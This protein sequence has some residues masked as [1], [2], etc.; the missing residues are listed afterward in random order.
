MGARLVITAPRYGNTA[1]VFAPPVARTR[2]GPDILGFL[3]GAYAMMLPYQVQ[4]TKDLN[5]ALADCCLLLILLLAPGQLKYRK[6]AWT[7]W[8]PALIVV[9]ATGTLISALDK[10]Q[11]SRYVLFNKDAGLMLLLFSYAAVTSAV[12]RWQDLRRLLRV[13]LVGVVS[14]NLVAVAAFFVTYFFGVDTPFT[15]Y[16]GARLSGMMLD[17]NAYGGLLVVALVICEGAS[18][19]PAPLFAGFPLLFCRLTLGTGILLTFSRSAWV[20]LGL[21]LLLLCVV[22]RREAIRLV[23][24][25]LVGSLCLFLVTGPRFL[26]YFE[27]MAARPEQGD[28]RFQLMHHALAEFMR[29]PLLGGGIASF[30]STEGTVVHNTALWFLAD[31]GIVG[32]FVL[33]GYMGS[34]FIRCCWAYRSAPDEQ[35]PVVLAVLLA[36]TAMLGLAMGIEAFYQRHWWL[37]VALIGSAYS[38]VCR[39]AHEE[40]LHPAYVLTAQSTT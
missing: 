29:H 26:Q 3:V 31:F 9:F 27:A 30:F 34:F 40:R 28:S 12:R 8:H 37:I 5:F 10:G 25:G 21:A 1:S 7:I 20:S 15:S 22:R 33:L 35:K 13:F 32:L 19:G 4:L 14:Q 6:P 2:Q 39:P 38:I 36:H 18:W 16:G 23:F 17:A 11:L 24:A